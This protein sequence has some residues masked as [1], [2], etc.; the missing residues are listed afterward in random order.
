MSFEGDVPA[1][2]VLWTPIFIANNYH[3]GRVA[4]SLQVEFIH[5]TRLGIAVKKPFTQ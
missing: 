5:E 2:G 3:C 4:K 1:L